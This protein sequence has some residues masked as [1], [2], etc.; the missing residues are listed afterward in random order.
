MQGS[1]IPNLSS[2]LC[3]N[4]KPIWLATYNYYTLMALFP[5][6]L[7]FLHSAVDLGWASNASKAEE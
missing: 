2:C 6:P 7:I 3:L 1:T 4:T 5:S